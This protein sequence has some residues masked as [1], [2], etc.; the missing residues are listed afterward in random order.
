MEMCL[1]V[2]MCL[3]KE[4]NLKVSLCFQFLCWRDVHKYQGTTLPK[5]SLKQ[6]FLL[7]EFEHIAKIQEDEK[8]LGFS[9]CSARAG[10]DP[11]HLPGWYSSMRGVPPLALCI[12]GESAAIPNDEQG[13]DGA[14]RARSSWRGRAACPGYL[15]CL[16]HHHCV[17][18]GAIFQQVAIGSFP[19][20][21]ST[22][23]SWPRNVSPRS[24]QT[25][26][27]N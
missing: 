14:S 22:T 27:H 1:L 6:V 24:E 21:I 10:W 7:W 25:R 17:R 15:L 18:E 8:C 3:Q 5:T 4:K 11:A 13:V 26:K 20:C 16:V 19:C 12:L 23:R 2:W 9:E